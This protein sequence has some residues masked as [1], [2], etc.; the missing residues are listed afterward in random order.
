MATLAD[1]FGK[2]RT[3]A[4]EN[5]LGLD[6]T[7]DQPG[8]VSLGALMSGD[9][10][11]FYDVNRMRFNNVLRNGKDAEY[12]SAFP[13]TQQIGPVEAAMAFS[14]AAVG[15]TKVVGGALRSGKLADAK[16]AKAGPITLDQLRDSS[17][18]VAERRKLVKEALSRPV[19]QW[20]PN[21]KASY[22]DRSLIREAMG[23]HPGVQQA[24][25]ER[26][27]PTNRTN[28]APAENLFT[29][30]NVELIKAQ[31]DRGRKMGGD[32]YYPS[33]YPIRAR[34]EEL[35]GPITFQDFVRANA[36]TS[37]QA[38][39]P[40]N[41]PNATVLMYMKKRGIPTTWENVEKFAKDMKQQHGV[42]FFLGPSHV[43]NWNMADQGKM[44]GFDSQQ[45]IASYGTNLEG[46]FRPY[47]LDTHETKGLSQGTAYFPYFD[48]QKGVSEREYGT[49]ER[50]AQKIAES[51]G[52]DPA[53]AQ[54][55]RWFGG[56][57][58][59]GL[60][61]PRGDYLN[62]LEDLVKY[63]AQQR[64][65]DTSRGAM[66]G[67]IDQILSGDEIL[68]P[69]WKRTPTIEYNTSLFE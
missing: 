26:L 62:T 46:N 17:T 32:T 15:S 60:R 3:L 21:D 29:K 54:A 65:W 9:L 10:D 31:I 57:E 48:K 64:G 37:P 16:K 61:S 55:A 11:T 67:K 69:Y 30:D 14:P 28:L 34:Y 39:L 68:L 12:A 58:L 25:L 36:A 6:M 53:N 38:P 51:L 20:V 52:L 56:G 59:T 41:I 49:I 2:A 44:T 47:T 23:G 45:K 40:I 5:V 7:K 13:D 19:E 35:N 33:T 22:F 24:P 43:D 50:N 66:Q 4:G 18:A 27:Q 8:M 42:G 1:L 63:N